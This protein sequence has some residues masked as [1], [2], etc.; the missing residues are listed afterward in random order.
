MYSAAK[1]PEVTATSGVCQPLS[2]RLLPELVA[3]IRGGDDQAMTELV[4]TLGPVI[5]EAAEALIGRP[6]RPHLDADDLL[7]SV[8]LELWL[9][10]RT[11][12]IVV[13]TPQKLNALVN[14]LLRRSLARHWRH[15]KPMADTDEIS[16]DA[17][18]ADFSMPQSEPPDPQGFDHLFNEL[19]GKLDRV[20]RSLVQL[21]FEGCTTREAA[22][23]LG[24]EPASLRVRLGRLRKRFAYFRE[25]LSS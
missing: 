9:G 25:R 14:V 8:E 15:L 7:Q 2:S 13:T 18:G 19:L 10:L 23:Q 16:L 21:R 3:R 5:R 11:G 22:R 4:A 17:T 12:R 24:L 20:D 6:L 1:T